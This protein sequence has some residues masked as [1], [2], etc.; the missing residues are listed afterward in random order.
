[1]GKLVWISSALKR[2]QIN[3]IQRH[4][5]LG[6]TANRPPTANNCKTKEGVE[7]QAKTGEFNSVMTVKLHS[8]TPPEQLSALSLCVCVCVNALLWYVCL[9]GFLP[10][11]RQNE[12]QVNA[13]AGKE[14]EKDK[15]MKLAALCMTEY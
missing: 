14:D 7:V 6:K 9:S 1:M 5:A 2:G 15:Y 4:T 8:G 13:N 12:W 10:H 11:N 3:N